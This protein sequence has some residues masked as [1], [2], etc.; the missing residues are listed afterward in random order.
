MITGNVLPAEF[1]Q[2]RVEVTDI[3]H[4]SSGVADFD[5]VANAKR[6]ANQNVNPCDETFH[7]SL[8][9]QP[10]DNRA[11]SKRGHRAVPIHE[12]DRHHDESNGEP[13]HQMRYALEGET[14]RC[15]LDTRNSNGTPAFG[16]R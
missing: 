2:R 6:L 14:S 13:H 12:D 5:A 7:R 11:N 10:D 4:V 9:R 1:P 3:N 15:I 16:G 8:Y